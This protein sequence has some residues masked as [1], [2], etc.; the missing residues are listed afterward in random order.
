MTEEMTEEMEAK[1]KNCRLAMKAALE[2]IQ[3]YCGTTPIGKV[4]MIDIRGIDLE[5]PDEI[6]EIA[7]QESRSLDARQTEIEQSEWVRDKAA[8]LCTDWWGLLTRTEPTAGETDECITRVAAEMGAR[9]LEERG[10]MVE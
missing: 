6:H 10:A 7:M 2:A 5:V 4:R 9:I 8:E 3:D 1:A